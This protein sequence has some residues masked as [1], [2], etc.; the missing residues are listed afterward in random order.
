MFPKKDKTSMLDDLKK[1]KRFVDSTKRCEEEVEFKK[2]REEAILARKEK[3]RQLKSD[4][5]FI[6]SELK[7]R[8]NKDD[9]LKIK[10]IV[11]EMKQMDSKCV[12]QNRIK[13]EKATKVRER[14][15]PC[16]LQ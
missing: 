13:L 10:Q 16:S 14:Q 3:D 1:N 11:L 4:G 15:N 6:K 8:L 2:R 7:D 9:K 5:S 12:H